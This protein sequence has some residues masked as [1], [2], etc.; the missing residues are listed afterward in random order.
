MTK[1]TILG[2]FNLNYVKV[3]N[4]HQNM[5]YK[6]Y[7]CVAKKLVSTY[8]I[9]SENRY[10]RDFFVPEDSPLGELRNKQVKKV[11][12]DLVEFAKFVLIIAVIVA[13]IYYVL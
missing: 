9:M 4:L 7:F 2:K 8:R 13:F 12:N 6:Y 10:E 1:I 5:K 3:C 11:K